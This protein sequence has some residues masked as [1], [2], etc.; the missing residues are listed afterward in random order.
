[1]KK[2]IGI[3]GIAVMAMAMF[4][5]TNTNHTDNVNLSSLIAINIANAESSGGAICEPGGNSCSTSNYCRKDSTY[6]STCSM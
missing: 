1:M 3:V 6:G 5:S 4:F 2:L